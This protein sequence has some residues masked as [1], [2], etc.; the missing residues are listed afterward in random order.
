MC[1]I[2]VLKFG[3]RVRKLV[4]QPRSCLHNVC[5]HDFIFVGLYFLICKRRI[6]LL[7]VSM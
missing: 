3:V 1:L 7:T 2:S 5:E 4:S 6:I